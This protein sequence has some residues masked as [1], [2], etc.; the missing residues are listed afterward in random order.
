MTYNKVHFEVRYIRQLAQKVRSMGFDG[1]FANACNP[2]PQMGN[3][4]AYGQLSQNPDEPVPAILKGFA[5][6]IAQPGSVDR[7]TDIFTFMENH[8]WW[9]SQMPSQYQLKPLPCKL[10]TYDA[11]LAALHAVEP[12]QQSP[13][14]LLISPGEYLAKVQSTLV[15]MKK[16]YTE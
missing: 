10:A 6:L 4:Y 5:G 11:A 16:N 9:G 15:F 3:I 14:P 7:L 8:S 13:T 12:L 1:T 2:Q